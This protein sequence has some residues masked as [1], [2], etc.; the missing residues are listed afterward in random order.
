MVA[1]IVLPVF[2]ESTVAEK[3]RRVCN[4][5]PVC[6][7]LNKWF[8]GGTAAGNIGD[9]YDNRDRGHSGLRR[10]WFPQIEHVRYS[11]REI[12]KGMDWG[13][14]TRLRP[15]VTIGNS[16]TSGPA[17]QRGSNVRAGYYHDEQ[18]MQFLYHQYRNGNLY[19]YPEHED[20]DPGHNGRWG[21]GD[22]F[23]TNS[24]YVVITQGSSASDQPFLMAFAQTLAAFHPDLKKALIETRMLMPTVQAIF[25]AS[26]RNVRG[27]RAYLTGRAHPTVFFGRHLD[28][29]KMV[30]AAHA[31]Q[32]E[33][34]P[35][36]VHL[37]LKEEAA[38]GPGGLR[39]PMTNERL[40]TTPGVIARI[41]RGPAYRR[42]M[43]VSARKSHALNHEPLM[44]EWVVLRG[45]PKRIRIE[46]EADGAVARVTVEYHA[47]RPIAPGSYMQS[48]RLD[49]GVFAHNGHGYSAPAFLTWYSLDNE[50]RTYDPDGRLIE[51]DYDAKS[52]HLE[53]IDWNAVFKLFAPGQRSFRV[54]QVTDQFDDRQRARVRQLAAEYRAGQQALREARS[55]PDD[56]HHRH[57]VA[58]AERKL[59]DILNKRRTVLGSIS[60]RRALHDA[61]RRMK[62]DPKWYLKH[63]G[64]IDA[65]ARVADDTEK[66]LIR[67]RIQV[68]RSRLGK[69]GV[70]VPAGPGRL[71]LGG[72]R[73]D[74]GTPDERLTGYER[75]ELRRFQMILLAGA[76]YPDCVK[77]HRTANYVD[78]RLAV[79]RPRRD[80]Y[81]YDEKGELKARFRHEGGSVFVEDKFQVRS[82]N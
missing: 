33:E 77:G 3:D 42:T 67:S 4:G 54:R 6:E 17:K 13:A 78:S 29:D 22:L 68:A 44:F 66:P 24:P 11:Q 20:H 27:P 16:S 26:N 56:K 23:A 51:I 10:D 57:L 53:I 75:F 35:P 76:V 52:L 58:V 63:R 59:R 46:P 45:D 79:A 2:A 74:K 49:I 18:G 81:R 73:A 70:F 19:V 31:L 64:E 62:D 36:L 7:K 40:C 12:A 9:F 80:V 28:P 38:L 41:W 8:L 55:G 30:E 34:V 15:T 43:R 61:F 14:Q 47:R 71:G 48:N 72:S 21:Y 82:T 50:R 5:G 25:R 69:L 39:V 65:L 32:L 37:E 60:L 1:C